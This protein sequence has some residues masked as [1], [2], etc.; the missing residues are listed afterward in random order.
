MEAEASASTGAPPPPKPQAVA[1]PVAMRSAA[2]VVLGLAA[3]FAAAFALPVLSLPSLLSISAASFLA[4]GLY[5]RQMP[6]ARMNAGIGARIGLST[7]VMLTAALAAVLATGLVM[8]RYRLHA[9]DAFDA[10]WSTQISLMLDR[11]QA[12]RG[13]MPPEAVHQMETPEFRAGS[14]LGGLGVLAVV[15]LVTTTGSGAFAGSIA[16]RPARPA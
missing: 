11:T 8:A 1:W 13:P 10:Q 14:M 9:M 16:V 15:L 6:E 4:V 12:A 7:G 3:L 2:V 5:R